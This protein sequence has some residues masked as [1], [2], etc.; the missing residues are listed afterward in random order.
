MSWGQKKTEQMK[1]PWRSLS[2]NQKA[3]LLGRFKL[4]LWHR[5]ATETT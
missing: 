5:K 3:L 1:Q 2:L 4:L